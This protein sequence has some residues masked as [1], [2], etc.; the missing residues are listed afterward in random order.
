MRDTLWWPGELGRRISDAKEAPHKTGKK[1]Y[2]GF[3]RKRELNG[4]N[5]DLQLETVRDTQLFVNSLHP[6]VEGVRLSELSDKF[7]WRCQSNA[8]LWYAWFRASFGYAAQCNVINKSYVT[9]TP[10][11]YQLACAT[12][13]FYIR[14]LAVAS[15]SLAH[16]AR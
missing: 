12:L 10:T 9:T 15:C 1:G 2:R 8:C 6:P 4:K 3:W 13:C 16:G 14:I 5:L 7:T 11:I